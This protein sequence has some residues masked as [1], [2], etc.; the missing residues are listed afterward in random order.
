MP[1]WCNNV[2][3]VK[4]PKEEVQRFYNENRGVCKRDD[5]DVN[6]ELL[7]SKSFPE[8]FKENEIDPST[9][10]EFDWWNWRINNWGTKWEP[11]DPTFDMDENQISYFFDTAWSP[12]EGWFKKVIK[13]YPELDFYMTFEEPG[14]AFKGEAEGDKG[15]FLY[16][17][18]EDMTDKEMNEALGVEE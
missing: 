8:P 7:F 10:K 18:C 14:M 2:L 1:N 15:K 9:D 3:D 16:F 17:K 12:P 6:N 11:S 4:G 5:G 13:L